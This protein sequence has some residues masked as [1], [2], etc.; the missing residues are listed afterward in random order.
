MST[1]GHQLLPVEAPMHYF[2]LHS[3]NLLQTPGKLD[4]E[5]QK[6]PWVT[7]SGLSFHPGGLYHPPSTNPE[8]PHQFLAPPIPQ[9]TTPKA[10]QV[11]QPGYSWGFHAHPQCHHLT[12]HAV[13]PETGMQFSSPSPLG[14]L[15]YISLSHTSILPFHFQLWFHPPCPLILPAQSPSMY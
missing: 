7:L 14:Q 1:S 15:L 2:T 4:E 11:P 10:T 13:R 6:A 5:Y 12:H 8:V 9:P 3:S